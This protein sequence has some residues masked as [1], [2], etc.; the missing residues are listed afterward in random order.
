[1]ECKFPEPRVVAAALIAGLAPAIASA[2][3]APPL[4][5]T[6]WIGTSSEWAQGLGIGLA[7]VDLGVL[8]ATWWASG[9]RGL[10][11][12]LKRN[13]LVGIAILPVVI[14][15]F[16]YSYGLEKSK[17][18]ESCGACH[19]M[20]PYVSDLQNPA[21]DSLA[22]VHFKN[23]YIQENHCYT[24][25]SDYGMFGTVK[26]KWEGLGHVVRYTLHDYS[27]PLKIARPY[28]NRRCLSCHGQSQKFL[29]PEAHSVEDQKHLVA[30]DMSCLDCHGPAHPKFAV[31]ASR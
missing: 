20:T 19:V 7:I 10:T 17:S 31:K 18:V 8:I 22:A 13:L 14:I 5:P 27:L 11:S 28:S 30:G 16:G 3:L 15:F 29:N 9:R 4:R 21:S 23:R 26:A 24:C 12:S 1:M 2:A 6:G 25:H